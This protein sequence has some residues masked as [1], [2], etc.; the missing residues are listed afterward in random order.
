MRFVG[1]MHTKD[2]KSAAYRTRT[3]VFIQAEARL[4]AVRRGGR[5]TWW[6]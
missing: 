1:I 2:G 4:A 6:F 3:A 5:I